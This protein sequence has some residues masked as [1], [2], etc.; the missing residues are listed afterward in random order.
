MSRP[1]LRTHSG[2]GEGGGGV[3]E[4]FI[5]ISPHGKFAPTEFAPMNS[6]LTFYFEFV[7]HLQWIKEREINKFCFIVGTIIIVFFSRYE[8]DKFDTGRAAL[9]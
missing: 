5:P 7:N 3:E 4:R 6:T 2:G 8:K 1:L 9:C